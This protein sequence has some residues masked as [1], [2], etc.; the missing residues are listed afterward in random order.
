MPT[1]RRITQRSFKLSPW[2]SFDDAKRNLKQ[3]VMELSE[4]GGDVTLGK[5]P[6]RPSFL[7]YAYDEAGE[8]GDNLREAHR[9]TVAEFVK[10]PTSWQTIL[11][12]EGS[13]LVLEAGGVPRAVIKSHPSWKSAP[14]E[15]A[16]D[17][18]L[19]RRPGDLSA[20]DFCE[21]RPGSEASETCKLTWQ[22][23]STR[24][25]GVPLRNAGLCW[26]SNG[27]GGRH[28]SRERQAGGDR[29]DPGGVHKPTLT[30][31][32]TPG[33]GKALSNSRPLHHQ[34]SVHR[35]GVGGRPIELTERSKRRPHILLDRL[36]NRRVHDDRRIAVRVAFDSP[37]E[38][39]KRGRR[40]PVQ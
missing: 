28:V 21:A 15:Y 31:L 38:T 35:I 20:G 24:R 22:Q 25:N 3:L 1:K 23:L 40:I 8:P 18:L 4:R 16:R 19:Q 26:G 29:P 37:N 6:D 12:Y 32:A 39:I 14:V 10:K 9:T 7:I 33:V 34:A 2:M 11:R 5:S 36:N 27:R 30:W 17:R 13:C